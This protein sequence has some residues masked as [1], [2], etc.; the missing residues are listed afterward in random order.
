MRSPFQLDEGYD[1]AADALAQLY[2]VKTADGLS[3]VSRE[4]K[5]L[6]IQTIRNTCAKFHVALPGAP[7][8]TDSREFVRHRF[9]PVLSQAA[10][11]LA[12]A[13][14][15]GALVAPAGVASSPAPS[16]AFEVAAS[17]AASAAPKPAPAP[18]PAPSPAPAPA[19]APAPSSAP[20][21][22]QVVDLARVDAVRQYFLDSANDAFVAWGKP[23][24]DKMAADL[25]L[26]AAAAASPQAVANSFMTHYGGVPSNG[27]VDAF[28]DR[29]L[30]P[31]PP[32]AAAGSAARGAWGWGGGEAAAAAA[33][34]VALAAASSAASSA[35]TAAAAPAPAPAPAP[36]AVPSFFG[37]IP[38]KQ[39]PADFDE[40]PLDVTLPSPKRPRQGQ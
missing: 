1:R 34:S 8:S 30:A 23:A 7:K 11:R 10:A 17:A 29:V 36:M 16:A 28:L 4:G 13:A 5:L 35:A 26:A 39:R 2:P 33:S 15:P 24:V 37:R 3:Y 19:S 21:P 22:V 14:R 27:D 31:E 20:A 25:G 9:M 12:A 38:K 18:A 32:A 6:T 40:V